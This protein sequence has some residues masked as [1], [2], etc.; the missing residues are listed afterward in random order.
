ETLAGV[1]ALVFDK[2]GTL[3][4]GTPRL[5]DLRP[6]DGDA[7]GALRLAAAAEA[8]SEH[9]LAAAIVAAAEARGLEL[10]AVE[11]F[12]AVPGHGVR[13]RVAGR[14]VCVGAARLLERDG[15]AIADAV[16]EEAEGLAAA[17]KTPIYLAVDGAVQA[18]IAVAD[19][20]KPEATGVVAALAAGGRRV[21]MVTGDGRR[22]AEAIAREAGIA[23]D[24]VW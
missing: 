21:A 24:Q 7:E 23:A 12:T 10:P 4:E 16:R 6:V 13:A 14:S 3:T 22:V 18:L 20:L 11:A 15:I 1:D 19:A 9:P 5:T 2:T 8:G 17:G